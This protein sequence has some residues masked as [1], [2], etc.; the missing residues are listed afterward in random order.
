MQW[1]LQRLK[2]KAR[3]FGHQ[4]NAAML[5]RSQAVKVY[6][7]IYLGRMR[8]GLTVSTQ[9]EREY[10]EIQS[11]AIS[12]LLPK[13]GYN[14]HTAQAIVYG[15]K[16]DGG[17]GLMDLYSLQGSRKAVTL[18]EH[19]RSESTVGKTLLINLKWTQQALG[20]GFDILQYPGKNIPASTGDQWFRGLRKFLHKSDCSIALAAI[21][22]PTPRRQ[23]DITIINYAMSNR[24]SDAQI[25]SIQKV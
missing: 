16:E 25:F 15:P 14:R 17:I 23:G 9:S 8:Y 12:A 11:P 13:M 20:V 10:Q 24:L 6:Q 7:S 19:T 2:A 18:I 21:T 22:P 1:E 5:T 3:E 4:T